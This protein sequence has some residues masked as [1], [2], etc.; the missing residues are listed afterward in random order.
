MK[1]YL[2]FIIVSLLITQN[3]FA[4]QFKLPRIPTYDS[5]Y[6]DSYNGK[7]KE[8]TYYL[9]GDKVF[10]IGYNT[11]SVLYKPFF[12]VGGGR[13]DSSYAYFNG[14]HHEDYDFYYIAKTYIIN[15][16]YSE[17]SLYMNYKKFDWNN[18]PIEV[19]TYYF[20]K[21]MN[22]TTISH[23]PKY[24]IGKWIKYDQY[25]NPLETID[26]DNYSRNGAPIKFEGNKK[27]IDSLKTINNNKLVSVYGQD[28]VT[29]YI[30]WNL[31]RS[32]YYVTPTMHA[33][34][35]SGFS[36]LNNVDDVVQYVDLSYDIVID[37][38]RFNVIQLRI[39][40]T[41]K[42][43]GKT[44]I[45]GYDDFYFTQGLDVLNKGVFHKNVLEWKR[46]ATEKGFDVHSKAFNI[47]F[48]FT[49]DDNGAG[50]L[51]LILEY[52]TDTTITDNSFTN[53]L[54]QYEINPWTG[55]IV[56]MVSSAGLSSAI[57]K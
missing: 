3:A 55:E 27:I 5:V 11:G 23:C 8:K 50:T 43:I 16:K 44:N 37:S 6:V 45:S 24:K 29:K 38:N 26:Y 18:K 7:V 21:D 46:I 10:Q 49:P 54:K 1:K 35:P 53:E 32:G 56:E 40:K 30:R 9:N 47:R 25:G 39:S 4:Q 20:I 22:Y 19:G 14:P 48:E 42:L 33:E 12:H 15:E 51:R 36:L 57:D 34:Q 52:V 41:G 2:L 17:A 31:S 28:F 13:E